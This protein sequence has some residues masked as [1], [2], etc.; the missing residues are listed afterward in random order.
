[1]SLSAIDA[2]APAFEQMRR[3]LFSPFSFGQWVRFAIV[4]L[5]AGEM[6]GLGGCN[7]RFSFP[8]DIPSS[9]RPNQL[10]GPLAAASALVV[11]GVVLAIVL[12]LI[13]LLVFTYV[14]SRMRF[15]LFDSVIARRCKVREFWGRRSEPALNYFLWQLGFALVL[16]SAMVVLVV[17]P[18]VFAGLMGWFA[19]PREHL[20]PLVLGGLVLVLLVLGVAIAAGVIHVMTKDFVVPQMA[21]EGTGAVE[22][23]RRL[24]SMISGDRWSYAGYVGMKILLSIGAAIILGIITLLMMLVLL[25]PVGG[26]GVIAILG[27]RAAGLTWNPLTIA[28]AVVVALILLLAFVFLSALLSTPAIVFFPAYSIHFFAAR[29]E[30]LRTAIQ[31]SGN[32]PFDAPA[33]DLS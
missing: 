22:G 25:L 2:I 7:S 1:V 32:V 11:L 28:I 31:A 13:L 14:S 6:G 18:L 33:P 5:L 15:V 4:G 30:P 10:Q 19:N 29:Y 26:A 9:S 17:P 3:Q 21:M 27:G 8:F 12:G 23:W 20:L 16:L 24:T